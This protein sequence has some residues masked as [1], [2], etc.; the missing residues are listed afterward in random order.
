MSKATFRR[1]P[2]FVKVVSISA[3]LLLVASSSAK[4]ADTRSNDEA[5]VRKVDADWVKAAQSKRVDAWMAFYSDDA[6]VLPPNDKK[7]A[8]RDSIQKAVGDL[9]GL[10]GLVIT[11]QPS[12]I[13]VARSGDT[14]Y[15]Y[16]TYNV[17]F[18]DPNGKRITD[19]GKMVEIWKKQPDGR[20]KCAVDTWNS[21]LPAVPTSP[22][23]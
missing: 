8:T 2:T 7:A 19:T 15:L 18:D 16:G 4:P 6:V 17:S 14:A 10:P 22:T 11:W 13:D 3:V 12:K 21:D 23:K 20:W 5:E 9:L 1:K